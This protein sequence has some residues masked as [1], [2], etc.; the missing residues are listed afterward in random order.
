MAFFASFEIS[1]PTAEAGEAELFEQQKLTS[2]LL[3]NLF[4]EKIDQDE[5]IIFEHIITRSDLQSHQVSYIHN[6]SDDALLVRLCFNLKKKIK[7]P[8]VE[9][10]YVDRITVEID[11]N[12]NIIQVITHVS[13]EDCSEQ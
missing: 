13:I 8:N 2:H 7:I 3:I 5:L 4:L 9:N 6:M 12:G 11:K 1:I 10:A